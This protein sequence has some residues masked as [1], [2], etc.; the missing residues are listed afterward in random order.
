LS[1]I[2]HE[3]LYKVFINTVAPIFDVEK[4]IS[5]THGRQFNMAKGVILKYMTD[6][7]IATT[8]P[9]SNSVTIPSASRFAR[10]IEKLKHVKGIVVA[11][12]GGGAILSGL[13]GYWMT[14]QTVKESSAVPAISSMANVNRSART[15]ACALCSKAV[16]SVA[17]RP[18]A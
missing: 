18:C 3:H 12:A 1:D 5:R 15:P 10:W 16:C 6:N 7:T 4:K 9:Q 2:V 17:E 8:E 13:V 11:L 14:Y